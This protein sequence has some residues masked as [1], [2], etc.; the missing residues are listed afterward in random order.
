VAKQQGLGKQ[1]ELYQ[2]TTATYGA[3]LE[4]LAKAYEADPEKR[5]DLLQEIHITIWQSFAGFNNLCSLRTWMYRVA[6]NVATSH[7]IKDKRI[8]SKTWL[9]LDEL[10][11]MADESNVEERIDRSW[12]L[13]RLMKMIQQLD[14]LERQVILLYLEGLDASAIGE[15]TGISQSNAA[16]KIHRIKKTLIQRFHQGRAL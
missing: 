15:I 8:S 12:A 10:D 2:Q 11:D 1:D 5:R 16:T 3:A 6:H 14:P 9:D 7:V 4:R 13:E